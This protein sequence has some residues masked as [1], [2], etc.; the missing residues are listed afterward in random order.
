[1][2][3]GRPS[4]PI[5]AGDSG[6]ISVY[7]G[8]FLLAPCSQPLRVQA[9]Q[10]EDTIRVRLFSSPDTAATGPCAE[11]VRPWEYSL[12]V[13]QFEPGEYVVHVRHEG[14]LARETALDT[15]YR[16]IEILPP[17]ARRAR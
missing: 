2:A 6:Q 7:D 11:D 8:Y 17:R 10:A 5:V 12:L 9:S 1:M 16:G 3:S 4:A 14:D 15:L 13:G